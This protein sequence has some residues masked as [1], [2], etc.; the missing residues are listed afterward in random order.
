MASYIF[1]I[2]LCLLP[3]IAILQRVKWEDYNE[4]VLLGFSF[5]MIAVA[6]A[7]ITFETK[8]RNMYYDVTFCLCV[9]TATTLFLILMFGTRVMQLAEQFKEEAMNKSRISKLKTRLAE[10]KE[11]FFQRP[12]ASSADVRR[13]QGGDCSTVKIAGV[14]K[15]PYRH[16]VLCNTVD[17]CIY[18]VSTSKNSW[19]LWRAGQPELH[20]MS[21]KSWLSLNSNLKTASFTLSE[22][23]QFV[24]FENMVMIG[25]EGIAETRICEST[26]MQS[27]STSMHQSTPP[28]HRK[29]SNRKKVAGSS[30]CY[31][32][33]MEFENEAKA[34]AFV[35]EVQS[36]ISDIGMMKGII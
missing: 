31:R 33:R 27:T 26:N 9:W 19:S 1:I 18:Q 2:Y 24:A 5:V 16:K 32:I 36:E 6:Y 7:I 22:S 28:V 8:L 29:S 23:T 13:Q 4:S 17:A 15:N 30:I 11:S 35:K 3:M 34:L 25:C 21:A 20:H 12:S 10:K 14:K